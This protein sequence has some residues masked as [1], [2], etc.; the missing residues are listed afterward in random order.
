[1]LERQPDNPWLLGE[2]AMA[3]AGLGDEKAT[4]AALDLLLAMQPES[5]SAVTGRLV[6]EGRA[7]VLTRIGHKDEAIARLSYLM[8]VPCGGLLAPITQ[9]SLHLDL[10]FDPLRGDPRFP[11]LLR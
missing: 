2:L 4:M 10:E 11:A 1:M 3:H 9:A 6:L 5:K 8:N 7:R